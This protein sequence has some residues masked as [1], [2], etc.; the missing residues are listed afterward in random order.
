MLPF[1]LSNAPAAFRREMRVIF[2]PL[3]FVLVY[4]DDIL[5]YSYTV[6]ILHKRRVKLILI[7]K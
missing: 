2:D 4:L 6:D 1:G 3:P 7:A 5:M